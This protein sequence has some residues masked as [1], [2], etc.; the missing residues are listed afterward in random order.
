MCSSSFPPEDSIRA[1]GQ[2]GPPSGG[3]RYAFN[4]DHPDGEVIGSWF[5]EGQEGLVLFV[6]FYTSACRWSACTGCNLPSQSS[7]R[8]I[9]F[10]EIIRQIDSVFRKPE[11]CL[12]LGE[13]SKLIVSN[14][15]SV[16]DEVTFPSTALLHL[17]VQINLLLPRVRVVTFESRPE[18]VDLL[19]L[20]FMARVMKERPSPATLEIAV[21]FEA[22]DERI[23]NRLFRKGLTF[24]AFE[25]LA[26]RMAGAARGH[27]LQLKCYFMQKPVVGLTD[28]EAL[29]DVQRGIEYLHQVSVRFG[30]RINLHLNP[31][32][33]ARG[34][35]LEEAFIAGEYQPPRLSDV[36]QAVLHA[37]GT[38]ISVFVGLSDEGMAVSGG[39][40]VRP[41]DESWVEA[42]TE[43]NRTQD[44]DALVRV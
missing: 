38:S 21:G 17:L 39:S 3:K 40:F 28:E 36:A 10:P 33:V 30:V 4:E 9:A 43:F 42:L 16:L 26:E 37:R 2:P 35:P 27:T 13:I 44:F 19:E 31:T 23:R 14:N 18:Y 34:T 29:A 8:P 11:I 24:R 20:G 5:Q 6:V 1:G 41:G 7:S 22:F 25:T 32:Y 15:G 12:R